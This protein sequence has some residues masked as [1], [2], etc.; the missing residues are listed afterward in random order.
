LLSDESLFYHQ[1]YSINKGTVVDIWSLGTIEDNFFLY[2]FDEDS[3]YNNIKKEHKSD[4]YNKSILKRVYI[5]KN[6][7]VND[8]FDFT[9]P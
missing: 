7:L 3:V 2:V 5:S 9:Y 4:L 6:K 1:K 8:T